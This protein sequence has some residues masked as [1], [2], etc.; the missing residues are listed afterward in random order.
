MTAN[1][2]VSDRPPSSVFAIAATMSEA[3]WDRIHAE[4][5][6]N[7][8]FLK[9]ERFDRLREQL[10]ELMQRAVTRADPDHELSTTNRVKGRALV[11]TGGSGAGKTVT[12]QR[13]IQSFPALRPTDHDGV[14]RPIISINAPDQPS[15]AAIYGRFLQAIGYPTIG[16]RSAE[17]LR[18]RFLAQTE[19][20]GTTVIHIDDCA[21]M[22]VGQDAFRTRRSAQKVSACL[23]GLMEEESPFSLIISGLETTLE[24][25]EHDEA[26][27]RRCQHIRMGRVHEEQ[28]REIGLAIY[29][30]AQ[31]RGLS[32]D[33]PRELISRLV[34]AANAQFGLS[35]ELAWHAVARAK[36]SGSSSL[37]AEHFADAYH[38]RT[39]CE[40][41]LNV[42]NAADWSLIDTSM[43][44]PRLRS[45]GQPSKRGGRRG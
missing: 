42:F 18:Q 14:S 9:T 35:L 16:A 11:I 10:S 33:P 6:T 32:F 37:E 1:P 34:H 44:V 22:I 17:I 45:P 8:T 27:A 20:L 13:A 23:R 21:N 25:L 31:E 15:P 43:I 24:L 4:E 3:E 39:D 26:L 2:H 36:S 5:I 38:R 30:R 28:Y 40:P 12:L 29:A 41:G 7:H 19:R